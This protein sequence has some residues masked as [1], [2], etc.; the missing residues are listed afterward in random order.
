MLNK[1]SVEISFCGHGI[2]FW[3]KYD[4]KENA[5]SLPSVSVEKEKKNNKRFFF[6]ASLPLCFH[7]WGAFVVFW[8]KPV[9]GCTL[10]KS[11]YSD[12]WNLRIPRPWTTFWL[13]RGPWAL[14][15]V[16]EGVGVMQSRV[17]SHSV[18]IAQYVVTTTGWCAR[19][20]FQ[21][22]GVLTQYLGPNCAHSA[23]IWL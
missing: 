1:G 9:S 14:L 15:W 22:L 2:R 17:W 20:W 21:S 8:Y 10:R 4:A 16:G 19:H 23:L 13:S 11:G 5:D 3:K 7:S 18:H 6:F 12:D